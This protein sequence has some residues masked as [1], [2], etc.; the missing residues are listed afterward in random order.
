MYL[1][2]NP[3]KNEFQESHEIETLINHQTNSFITTDLLSHSQIHLYLPDL[4]HAT[5]SNSKGICMCQ[6]P[7]NNSPNHMVDYLSPITVYF[8]P[9]FE[10]SL[11][12]GTR[13]YHYHKLLLLH[14]WENKCCIRD[15]LH[16]EAQQCRSWNHA[17][18]KDM[19]KIRIML[20]LFYTYICLLKNSNKSML[21][22]IPLE[23]IKTRRTTAKAILTE[24]IPVPCFSVVFVR[25]QSKFIVSI[26]S[27]G[28]HCTTHL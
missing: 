13:K 4:K 7:H 16:K 11:L 26:D 3:Y 14:N 17:L 10:L 22:K 23:D 1:T 25:F 28:I 2:F 18:Q 27:I 9:F 12:W 19:Q 15:F 20:I 24:A 21:R 8:T 5:Y 6:L